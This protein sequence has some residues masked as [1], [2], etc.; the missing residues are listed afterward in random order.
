MMKQTCYF[1]NF[2]LTAL[3]LVCLMST[4]SC[5]AHTASSPKAAD[6]EP[7]VE[8]LK[9]TPAD[10]LRTFPFLTLREACFENGTMVSNEL[11]KEF[12]AVLDKRNWR[13]IV[14]TGQK[15][16]D[17]DYTSIN[18]HVLISYAYGKLGEKDREKFHGAVAEGLA[19]SIMSTGDGLSPE[20]AW[21]VYQVDEEFD[22]LKLAFHIFAV[23]AQS[24]LRNKE[25]WID[26]MQIFRKGRKK[27]FYF[28]ITEAF[29]KRY[30]KLLGLTAK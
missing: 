19:R 30:S 23:D 18:R 12:Q 27:T 25:R 20:S 22:L 3:L 4:V 21:H 24:L 10:G 13:E 1:G 14:E 5:S 15:L 7:L 9:T 2:L 29:E 26:V 17:Q 6:Y 11:K 8:R 16:L 28:D